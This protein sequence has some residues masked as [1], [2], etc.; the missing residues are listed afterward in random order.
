M[1]TAELGESAGWIELGMDQ[2]HAG[3]A[4]IDPIAFTELYEQ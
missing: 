3:G 4:G 2:T 1:S